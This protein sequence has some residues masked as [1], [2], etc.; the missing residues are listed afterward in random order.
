MTPPVAAPVV[1]PAP[2][3]AETGRLRRIAAP[4]GLAALA[5]TGVGVAQL[6][7][8]PFTDRVPLCLLHALTGLQC[9][10]CGM[11]RAVHA[12]LAGDVA[13]ALRCNVLLV[14]LVPLAAL[15]WGR[16]FAR[17]WRAVPRADERSWLPSPLALALCVGL[18]VLFGILRNLPALWFLAPPPVV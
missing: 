5:I 8:D 18:V 2:V 9:P 14:A 3:R 17:R 13:L 12:L 10:G 4:A 11:T 7:F 6:V 15:A 1:S 16:W